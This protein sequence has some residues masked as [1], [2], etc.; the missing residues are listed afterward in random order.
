MDEPSAF[1]LDID[2]VLVT[3]WEPIPGAVGAVTALRRAGHGLRFHTNTT[4][5]TTNADAQTT[6]ANVRT[7][8]KPPINGSPPKMNVSGG[9]SRP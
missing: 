6:N 9:R 4:T 5:R 8:P 1:L 2:G 3:A 7:M